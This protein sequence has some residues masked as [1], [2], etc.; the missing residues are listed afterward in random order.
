MWSQ[1]EDIIL[2][3]LYEKYGP[4]WQNIAFYL[5]ERTGIYLFGANI[6]NF[7]NFD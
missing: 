1:Q 5:K 7:H 6:K 2:L 4:N 3:E